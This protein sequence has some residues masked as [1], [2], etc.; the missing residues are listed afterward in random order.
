MDESD[1]A[2]TPTPF[3]FAQGRL[4]GEGV[5]F[6]L[7]RVAHRAYRGTVH[8]RFC[9]RSINAPVKG[10]PTSSRRLEGDFVSKLY[11]NF[12]IEP[13]NGGQV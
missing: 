10:A 8:V 5:L 9:N 7:S 1:Y 11:T 4:S 13:I 12:L 6:R 3:D 2:L